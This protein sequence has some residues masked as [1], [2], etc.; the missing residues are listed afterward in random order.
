MEKEKSNKG[1]IIIL[2]VIIALLLCVIGYLLFGKGEDTKTNAPVTTPEVED[3]TTTTT[4]T[5]EEEKQITVRTYRFFGF[6]EESGPDMYTTLKLFSNK[7]YEFYV[8]NCS[9]ILKYSGD[10]TETT[11]FITLKGDVNYK[12]DK[13]DNGNTLDFK[14]ANVEICQDS[15]GGFLLESYALGF[16]GE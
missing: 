15:G 4:K 1:L 10:Y 11:D 5:E 16:I 14:G 13:R 7:K 6:D 2:I 3:N 9:E 12:F 8:N